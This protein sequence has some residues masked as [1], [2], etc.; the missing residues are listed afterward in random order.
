[1]WVP[2]GVRAGEHTAPAG[3]SRS[4]ASEPAAGAMLA[5]RTGGGVGRG[6]TRGESGG[7]ARLGRGETGAGADFRNKDG[8][9][10]GVV[11]LM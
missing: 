5:A 9:M 7:V 1:M 3:T 11:C 6:L 10:G 4:S 8:E 2:V